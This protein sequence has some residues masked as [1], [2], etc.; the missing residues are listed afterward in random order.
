MSFSASNKNAVPKASSHL[1][2]TLGRLNSVGELSSGVRLN[3]NRKPTVQSFSSFSLSGANER[4]PRS[5]RSKSTV[6][7]VKQKT[8]MTSKI[9]ITSLVKIDFPFIF[10]SGLQGLAQRIR[11]KHN[12]L[13]ITVHSIDYTRVYVTFQIRKLVDAIISATEMTVERTTPGNNIGN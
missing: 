11:R 3:S 13:A 4:S 9:S 12:H 5:L 6:C 7:D 8:R 10:V 1:Q 2:V